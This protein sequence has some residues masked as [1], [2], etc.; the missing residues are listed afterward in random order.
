MQHY[1][2][3]TFNYAIHHVSYLAVG[4]IEC[5]AG[6]VANRTFSTLARVSVVLTGMENCILGDVG[7]WWV[8]MEC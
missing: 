4:L 1:S 5:A 7:M 3:A 2:A 6:G 8:Y